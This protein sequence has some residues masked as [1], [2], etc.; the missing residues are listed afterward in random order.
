MMAFVSNMAWIDDGKD[1]DMSRQTEG[2]KKSPP[3]SGEGK[4]TTPTTPVGGSAYSSGGGSAIIIAALIGAA[5]TLIVGFLAFPPFQEFVRNGGD[6]TQGDNDGCT[7][8]LESGGQVVMDADRYAE[9]VPGRSYSLNDNDPVRDA[10][11]ISWHK[12]NEF[13]GTMQALPDLQ[14]TNTMAKTNGPALVYLVQFKTAGKYFVYIRGFGPSDDGDSIHVGL[15]GIPVTTG[16]STGFSLPGDKP[17]PRWVGETDSGD[18]VV[19]EVQNPGLNTFY[20][21]MRENGV[22]VQR[23]WLDT[24]AGKI[25]NGD[26][27][28]GPATSQCAELPVS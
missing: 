17:L 12:N 21:W 25:S 22:N 28:Y 9:Q 15:G 10:I 5:A 3:R 20:I 1:N 7:V 23:I 16:Y 27:T 4:T 8:F 18:P 2:E 24:G 11:G 26:T 6:L 13:P 19:I 14:S